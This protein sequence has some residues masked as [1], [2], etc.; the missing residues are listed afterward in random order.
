MRTY[1][2]VFRSQQQHDGPPSPLGDVALSLL[3]VL[4]HYP[5]HHAQLVNGVKDALHHLQDAAA[6]AGDSEGG[7]GRFG[8]PMP[9]GGSAASIRFSQLY[10]FFATGECEMGL[11]LNAAG[12]ELLDATSLSSKL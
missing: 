6:A 10:H 5:A 12:R 11:V 3:L 8:T 4:A 2:Y 1:Q 7:A 9:A